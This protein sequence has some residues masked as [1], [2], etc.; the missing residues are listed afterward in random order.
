[1]LSA[2][3]TARA[4]VSANEAARQHGVPPSTLKDR[5]SGRVLHG[6]KPGPHPYLKPSEE[7]E[8][9]DYLITAAKVGYGKTRRQIKGIAESVAKEKGILKGKRISNGWWRRFLERNPIIS[10]VED[11]GPKKSR[12]KAQDEIKDDQCCAC[13]GTYEEDLLSGTGCEWLQCACTRWIHEDCVENCTVDSEG[14]DR[15]C[16][17]CL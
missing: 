4:G 17:L 5:L 8:L 1:M 3:E 12:V 14:R 2:I 13:F 15:I 7:S 6:S 11:D 16:P 9:S 10:E